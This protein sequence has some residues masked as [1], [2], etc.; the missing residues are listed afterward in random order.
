M[1]GHLLMVQVRF[2]PSQ[3]LKGLRMH[4]LESGPWKCDHENMT[5]NIEQLRGP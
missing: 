1:H 3:G 5:S 4:F 2:T